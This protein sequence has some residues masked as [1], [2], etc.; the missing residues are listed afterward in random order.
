MV[1]CSMCGKSGIQVCFGEKEE[2]CHPVHAGCRDDRV[3]KQQP[4]IWARLKI[5]GNRVS[6]SREVSQRHV[7]QQQTD[8]W[9]KVVVV[10]LLV[11]QGTQEVQQL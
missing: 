9:G 2:R 8:V 7:T 5:R 1:C 3:N 11:T 6:R 10:A 4:D